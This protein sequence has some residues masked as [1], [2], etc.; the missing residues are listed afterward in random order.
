MKVS[1]SEVIFQATP[2][3]GSLVFSNPEG[4]REYLLK[5][6]GIPQSV[7]MIDEGHLAGRAKLNRFFHGPVLSAGCI[8]YD[9]AGYVG[10]D[11]FFVKYQLQ[12]E[13]AKDYQK[14]KNG[15]Y[16]VYVVATSQMNK[17]RFYRFVR[18][19]VYRIEELGVPIE[20]I[21]SEL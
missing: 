16:E 19:S 4:L 10:C 3:N 9:M 12:L 18:D 2:E 13:F 11:K 20:I 5:H 14:M 17:A 1:E 6:D 21:E 15:E 7:A 8:A